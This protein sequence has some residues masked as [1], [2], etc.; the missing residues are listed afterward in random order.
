VTKV[1]YPLSIV[2]NRDILIEYNRV[3]IFL[4][5]IKRAKYV[6]DSVTRDKRVRSNRFHSC[7]LLRAKLLQ[8]VNNLQHF[9]F[10]R[11]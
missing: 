11:V 1:P 7:L 4:M 3:F 10:N 5:Q 2:F 6:L 9:I 8:F